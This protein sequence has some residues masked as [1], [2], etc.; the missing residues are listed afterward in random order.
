MPSAH[1]AGLDADV[2]EARRAYAKLKEEQL[3]DVTSIGGAS[4]PLSGLLGEE[5][6]SG[7]RDLWAAYHANATSGADP[8]RAPG[9]INKKPASSTSVERRHHEEPAFSTSVR[10][11]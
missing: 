9:D 8:R 6:S 7:G 2:A 5:T 4:D 11:H 3:P 10:H 1:P